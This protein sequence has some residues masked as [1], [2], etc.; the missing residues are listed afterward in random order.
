MAYMPNWLRNVLK[1]GE[2]TQAHDDAASALVYLLAVFEAAKLIAKASYTDPQQHE[3][4][5]ALKQCET[6]LGRLDANEPWGLVVNRRKLQAHNARLTA[7]QKELLELALPKLKEFAAALLGDCDKLETQVRAIGAGGGWNIT[8]ALE[9]LASVRRLVGRMDTDEPQTQDL[10]LAFKAYPI[11]EE[12]TTLVNEY[13]ALDGARESMRAAL[14][15][16]RSEYPGRKKRINEERKYMQLFAKRCASW[17]GMQKMLDQADELL[18]GMRKRFNELQSH[19]DNLRM[20]DA[21]DLLESIEADWATLKDLCDTC[22]MER[23]VF[24]NQIDNAYQWAMY[25]VERVQM[26]AKK[27]GARAE[28]AA[29]VKS[30]VAKFQHVVKASGHLLHAQAVSDQAELIAQAACSFRDNPTQPVV[31]AVHPEFAALDGFSD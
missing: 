15:E 4:Q 3:A 10:I 30:F 6:L 23:F 2:A 11:A 1:H 12:A 29:V 19:L 24:Y 27:P 13:D 5:D 28:G 8:P 17:Q 20:V 7:L 31:V 22:V 25:Q 16:L 9:L 14:A 21:G 26:L 18:K